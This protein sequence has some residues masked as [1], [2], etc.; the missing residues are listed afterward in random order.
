MR[1]SKA[2]RANQTALLEQLVAEVRDLRTLTENIG[3]MLD[4]PP[5]APMCVVDEHPGPDELLGAKSVAEML[6]IDVSTVRVMCKDGRLPATKI[7]KRGD[8]GI[9]VVDVYDYA[10]RAGM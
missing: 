5:A 6:G 4:T 1:K 8:W 7:N 3:R 9:R 2:E 10:Q